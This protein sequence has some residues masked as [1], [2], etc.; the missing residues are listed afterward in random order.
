MTGLVLLDTVVVLHLVRGN[1]TGKRID[2]AT[3]LSTRAERPL[4]STITVGEALGFAQYRSWGPDKTERLRAY[5]EQFVPI[6]INDE[7]VFDAYAAMHAYLVRKGRKLS[8]ND[9]WIA[10]CARATSATLITTDKDLCLT[11]PQA[12]SADVDEAARPSARSQCGLGALPRRAA[13]A[14][15][16]PLC[17]EEM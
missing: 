7:V 2:A 13:P 15:C 17:F 10:A 3:G 14:V 1:D 12:S 9:V 6:D 8:D 4:I 5:L 11:R 16:F